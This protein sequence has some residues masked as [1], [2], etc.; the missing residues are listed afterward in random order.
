MTP[1]LK[2]LKVLKVLYPSH[3]G[4]LQALLK[5]PHPFEQKHSQEDQK[6]SGLSGLSGSHP[7]TLNV[8]KVF[9]VVFNAHLTAHDIRRTT[10][11]TLAASGRS[12]VRATSI[13][14]QIFSSNILKSFKHLAI[15]VRVSYK[16]ATNNPR[17]SLDNGQ[18]GTPLSSASGPGCLSPAIWGKNKNQLRHGV[19]TNA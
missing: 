14:R 9:Q 5:Y 12:H 15:G 3:S 17:I 13:E 19:C 11:D 8:L 10:G 7:E 2:V 6:H 1:C 16:P 18:P 4:C